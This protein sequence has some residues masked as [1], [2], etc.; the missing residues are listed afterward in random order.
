MRI[1][2][3]LS[4][5][6]GTAYSAFGQNA[7]YLALAKKADS[8]YQA[9]DYK[10]SALTYSNAFK[11]NGWV[12]LSTDRY[13]AACSW[14]LANNADSA[15]FQLNRI[16]TKAGYANY[17]H[18]T[19]DADLVSLHRDDR[20]KPLLVLINQNKEKAEANFNKPLVVQL[21]SIYKDDQQ[22]RQQLNDV[23]KQYGLESNQVKALWAII[24]KKDAANLTRVRAILDKYGWLGSNVIG[25]QGNST[26]FLVIQ[27]ADQQTQETYLPMMRDAVK[28]GNAAGS[29]LALLE[30]RVALGQHKRQIYG[31]QI[32]RNTQT[33]QYYVLPLEDPDNVDK[34]RADV[35]LQPLAEYVSRW[36]IKW[37]VEQYKKDQ[38][39][40]EPN[41]EH[42]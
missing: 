11:A 13:N 28:K 19:T 12:G 24:T 2:L 41:Q 37:D 32:G 16:A 9:K 29:A 31:S 14:A 23:E 39:A 5:C 25:Q 22:Y 17:N 42:K 34:R 7:T 26:L 6:L 38:Q 15:F 8:L 30:D 18:I 1:F 35:G 33:K 27:H 21:D 10:N 3:C 4:F 20:W 40:N 36:Q